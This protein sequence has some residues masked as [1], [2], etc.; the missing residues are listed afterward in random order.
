VALQAEKLL[1]NSR[2]KKNTYFEIEVKELPDSLRS[3]MTH[4]VFN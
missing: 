3:K 2:E 4:M 1:L